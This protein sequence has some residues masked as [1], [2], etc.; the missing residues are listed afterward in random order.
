MK[1]IF[2][3][4]L[5][6]FAVCISLI[7][8]NTSG[9]ETNGDE[10]SGD[11][12]GSIASECETL[13]HNWVD[14]SCDVAKTCARCGATEG[15]SIGH[16]YTILKVSDT[17]HWYECAVCDE[18]KPNG[19]EDHTGGNA[20]CLAK[21]IC[22]VC[23]TSYGELGDHAYNDNEWEYR[24]SDG[25]A[26]KCTLCDT[27]TTPIAHT[28]NIDA[29]TEDTAKFCTA[30]GCG[31]IIAQALN[32]E[33]TKADA[34][35]YN[36]VNHWHDCTANDGMEYDVAPHTFDNSCDTDCNDGCGYTRQPTH[37]FTVLKNNESQHW[38]ECS[39]CNT[40]NAE[41]RTSH[42]FDES[43]LIYVSR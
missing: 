15:T 9:G 29:P 38:Y 34:W 13:G 26:H 19:K 25:H 31:Y 4:L 21:A 36:T 1:K 39:V 5:M 40:E 41:S 42:S 27:Y 24:E 10:P 43:V 30:E 11:S 14:A 3:M 8:C 33:H 6:A 37:S 2:L 18:E 23:S 32:H 16:E 7:A 22:A 17:Q 12:G 35:E 20:T 28:P